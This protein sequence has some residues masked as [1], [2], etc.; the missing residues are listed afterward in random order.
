MSYGRLAALAFELLVDC[1]H[2]NV[3]QHRLGSL[4]WGRI[5]FGAGGRES[6]RN[7]DIDL[8]TG[9]YQAGDAGGG[10][11]RHRDGAHARTQ[12]RGEKAAA[13]GCDDLGFGDRFARDE[14]VAGYPTG[15]IL[16][17]FSTVLDIGLPDAPLGP[18]LPGKIRRL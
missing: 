4:L 12:Y 11:D 9:E 6:F 13:A 5:A 18:R 10:G 3:V 7:Q 14:R 8:I 17:F 2:P 15:K 16:Y 1:K